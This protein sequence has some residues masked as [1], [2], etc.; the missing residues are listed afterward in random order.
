MCTPTSTVYA[1][2]NDG[3]AYIESEAG[4]EWGPIGH[5]QHNQGYLDRREENRQIAMRSREESVSVGDIVGIPVPPHFHSH[6][7]PVR[8]LHGRVMDFREDA[9]GTRWYRIGFE[10]G[11]YTSRLRAI[12]LDTAI[13]S[14]L[15]TVQMAEYHVPPTLSSIPN[16]ELTM[17]A[18]MARHERQAGGRLETLRQIRQHR[19]QNRGES[20][21]HRRRRRRQ[22]EGQN[23]GHGRG[24]VHGQQQGMA[25]RLDNINGDAVE[26]QRSNL[27]P[28]LRCPD[29]IRVATPISTRRRTRMP[30]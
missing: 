26:R 12:E 28:G 25:Q 16:V 3:G 11:Y 19:R 24:R 5:R 9:R 27:R 8:Q 6:S 23:R 13:P 4:I 2:T 17:H 20:Q 1:T 30:R 10:F 29:G 22:D 15:S 18:I 14:P 7:G 21:R